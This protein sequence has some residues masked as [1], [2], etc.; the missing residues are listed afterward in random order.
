M[1]WYRARWSPG[2]VGIVLDGRAPARVPD[3][4]ISEL[5]SR[6]VG[7][8]V[9]LPD[10]PALRHGDA[11]RVTQGA[12]TGLSGLYAGQRPHERVLILLALLGG[13]RQAELPAHSI[14]AV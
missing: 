7:G 3:A 8:L 2:V 5:R 14:E 11:V 6:E 1:E 10:P 13:H 4:V 12:F 9:M